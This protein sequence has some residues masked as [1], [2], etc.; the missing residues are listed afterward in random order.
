MEL[1]AAILL[2]GPLGYFT[3]HGLRYYLIAWAV[4]FPFQTVVV[5][6]EATDGSA[7]PYFAVN[8]VIL[9][10]GVGLNRLGRRLSPVIR[11]ER[12]GAGPDA[13]EPVAPGPS[14]A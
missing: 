2:A 9:A 6:N 10:L 12:S 14:A 13:S 5:W 8:A 1:I 11:G 3:H 7:W 4:I